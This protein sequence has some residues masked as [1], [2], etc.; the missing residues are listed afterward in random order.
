[1]KKFSTDD[2]GGWI[3][4]GNPIRTAQVYLFGTI[5][6]RL[7][8]DR[9]VHSGVRPAGEDRNSH[10]GFCGGLRCTYKPGA[11]CGKDWDALRLR[12]REGIK[13]SY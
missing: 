7:T 2:P 8:K 4:W 1:M 13:A 3:L 6:Q 12:R 10:G 5:F 11:S 9:A